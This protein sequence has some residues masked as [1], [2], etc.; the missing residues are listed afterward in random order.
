MKVENG[1]HSAVCQVH[2]EVAHALLVPLGVTL[3]GQCR[4]ILKDTGNF[5][6][7]KVIH[8]EQEMMDNHLN[9]WIISLVMPDEV[10]NVSRQARRLIVVQGRWQKVYL[11]P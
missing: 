3:Y 6:V 2:S 5:A 9:L 4:I 10:R 1:S 7:Q 8:T 11:Q